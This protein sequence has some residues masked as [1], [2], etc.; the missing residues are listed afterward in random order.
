M[1]LETIY[2]LLFKIRIVT[3]VSIVKNNAKTIKKLI[4]SEAM[5]V[6][7]KCNTGKRNT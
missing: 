7:A 3:A 2:C 1:V 4:F 6:L 5:L